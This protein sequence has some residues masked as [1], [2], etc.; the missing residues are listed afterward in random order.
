M[1]EKRKEKSQEPKLDNT[2]RENNSDQSEE[3]TDKKEI[4]PKQKHKKD[5]KVEKI[6]KLEEEVSQLNDKYL[7]LYSE[8]DN[9]RKRTQ[10]EKIELSK[11]AAA[12]IISDMLPVL[13]DLERAYTAIDSTEDSHSATKDG[14]GLILNKFLNILTQA[15]LEPIKAIGE[16]FN[17]DF[18]EAITNIPAPSPDMKGKILDVIVKGYLLGGK[19]IR[20]AKVVVGN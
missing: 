20:F 17:T 6:E 1:E 16:E 10:R 5:D 9:Y 3:I 18:H 15:G 13:D 11:T 8:F 7:R 19:V 2:P 4:P 12:E 14:I